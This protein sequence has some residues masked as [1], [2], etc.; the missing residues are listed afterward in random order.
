[1]ALW[2][3]KDS[4][5]V[6]GTIAVTNGSKAVV[7]TG[8]TFTTQLKSGNTIVIANVEYRVESITDNTHLTLHADYATG[9][10]ITANEQ[11]AYIPEGSLAQVYGVDSG[12]GTN[13]EAQQTDNRA[14]GLRTPGWVKYVTYQDS[15]GNTRHKVETLVAMGTI[16]GDAADDAVLADD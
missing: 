3:N 5:A 1:M 4:K 9:L 16:A 2:G 10:S 8:T 12:P 13:Y 7:G 6:T 11:P 14:R 15:E